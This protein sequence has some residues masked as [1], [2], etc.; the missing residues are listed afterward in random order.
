MILDEICGH[1]EEE[2]AARKGEVPL[3][4]LKER[5]GRVGPA[6]DFYKALREPGMSLIAEFKR[7]SPSKG[8][9]MEDG[10]PLEVSSQYER[11][12]ARAISVLTDER[13]FQGSLGDLEGV[14]QNV[15][16]PCLRKDF[17]VD[18]YQ[19]YEARAAQADAVLLI[20]RVLSDEQLR[21]YLQ[22]AHELGMSALVESH[23]AEEIG[24]S[25]EAGAHII[26]I[27]NR[28]L[29]TFRVDINTTMELKRLVPG[30]KVLVSESGIRTRDHVRML[31]DGGVDAILVGEALVTS[32]DVGAQIRGLLSADESEDMRHHDFE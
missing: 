27:N 5:I 22:L 10:D 3:E 13:Y 14:R 4:R 12:G 16:V 9:M 32:K 11:A 21:D 18:G 31:E 25:L 15:S 6:R 1:K 7:A 29:A 30:G 2:V 8:T 20:A 28:D 26:G 17:V 23:D 24:R 19:V